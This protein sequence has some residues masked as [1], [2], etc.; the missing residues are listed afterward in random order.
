MVKDYKGRRLLFRYYDPR[1]LRVYL[2]TCLPNELETVFGPVKAYLVEGDGGGTLIQYR[3][4]DRGLI[5]KVVRLEAPPEIQRSDRA[6]ADVAGT[7]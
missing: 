5:E 6:R 3:V 4:D 1:V 7:R 2:P